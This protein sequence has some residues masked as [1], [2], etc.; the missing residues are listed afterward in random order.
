M[1]HRRSARLVLA[2]GSACLVLL[3]ACGTDEPAGPAPATTA[4]PA[5]HQGPQGQQGPQGHQ[6]DQGDHGHHGGGGLELWATQTAT[7]GTIVLDGN[8][9]ILYRSDADTN[10]PPTSR[11][12]GECT[13]KWVPVMLPDGAEPVLLGVEP[14]KVGTIRRGDGTT[15][16]TLG[17]WPL[18][19]VA[20][21]PGDHDGAGANGADGTWFAVTPTGDK[22]RP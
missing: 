4:P 15:Q 2:A 5:A 8:G 9:R 3:G 12:A 7:L 17:G 10:D 14:A 1:A 11:C 22:A 16:V 6:G 20:G 21:D 18:Y 19:T 13:H